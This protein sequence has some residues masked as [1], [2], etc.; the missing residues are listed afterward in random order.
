MAPSL[1]RETARALV[2]AGY[3]PLKRYLEMFGDPELCS[4]RTAPVRLRHRRFAAP[5]GR[6]DRR[7]GK[8]HKAA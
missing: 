7:K 5:H 1:D 3:M 4:D 2:D 8:I 6:S